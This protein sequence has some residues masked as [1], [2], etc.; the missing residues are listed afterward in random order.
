ML[1]VSVAQVAG[2]AV[3]E[4]LPYSGE[5]R[6]RGIMAPGALNAVRA[7]LPEGIARWIAG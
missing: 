6:V 7:S 5:D 1:G 4:S 2:V 3:S